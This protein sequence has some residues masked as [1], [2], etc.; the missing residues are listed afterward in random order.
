IG[1]LT[2]AVACDQYLAVGYFQRGV[3]FFKQ[4]LLAEALADFTDALA[5]LRGNLI[6]DYNPLGLSYR[7]HAAEIS[8]NRGLC[9]ASVGQIEAAMA[10]FDDAARTKP[11]DAGSGEYARIADAISLGSRAAQYCAPFDVPARIIFN[12]P[13][14]NS[15]SIKKAEYGV[16]NKSAAAVSED[17]SRYGGFDSSKPKGTP[18]K[19]SQG[20]PSETSSTFAPDAAA[21]NLGRSRGAGGPIGGKG[22]GDNP[23][24]SLPR[25]TNM[26]EFKAAAGESPYGS[27][28]RRMNMTE[29]RVAA[30]F[31]RGGG[32]GSS[33]AAPK[34]VDDVRALIRSRS[35]SMANSNAAT[36]PAAA[37]EG[38]RA[39]AGGYRSARGARGGDDDD[40]RPARAAGVG[41][42]SGRGLSRGRG[43][44]RATEPEVGRGGGADDKSGAGAGAGRGGR[45]RSRDRVDEDGP[46]MLQRRNTNGST[47][48]SDKVKIKCHF[49]DTRIIVVPVDVT[50]D[51]LS[52]RVQRKFGAAAPLTLKYRDSDGEMVLLTDQEDLEVA[53]E[54]HGLEYGVPAAPAASRSDRFEIW[55]ST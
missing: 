49:Q 31:A 11:Q 26:Q 6:M 45:S 25:R 48:G 42:A 19:K 43:E 50:F 35:S 41:G 9:F 44:N 32:G 24:G 36:A 39:G 4:D 18:P 17:D 28:P 1:S 7:L 13:V 37:D 52:V 5:Y 8:F 53:F 3:L 15:K 33:G 14:S 55:C 47:M 51:D 12:P 34:N 30:G 21:A 23:Y 22:L 54:M 2:R 40:E 27:L 16:R 46:S 38:T 29:A 20:L 10:D